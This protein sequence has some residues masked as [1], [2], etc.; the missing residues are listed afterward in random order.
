MMELDENAMTITVYYDSRKT[1]LPAIREAIA[2]IG[3]DADE[4]KANPAAY[5]TLVGCCKKA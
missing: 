1:N 4:L 5:E 2:N 3:H